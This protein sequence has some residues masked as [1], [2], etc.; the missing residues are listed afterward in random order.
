MLC[1]CSWPL[2]DSVAHLEFL[3]FSTNFKQLCDGVHKA[4]EVMVAHLLDLAVV[5]ANPPLQLLHEEPMLLSIVHRSMGKGKGEKNKNLTA[6]LLP[7][8]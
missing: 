4:L 8:I 6:L 5:I 3:C 7:L 1:P 2:Y